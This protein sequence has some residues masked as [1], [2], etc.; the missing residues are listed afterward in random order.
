MA[1]AESPYAA[2]L[3]TQAKDLSLPPPGEDASA[4]AMRL[5]EGL[6]QR[7]VSEGGAI[8]FAEFME[9]AL[10]APGLGYYSAGSAKLGAAGDFVTAP[11][12]SPLFSRSL[13][14]QC[15]QM[16]GAVG[17]DVLEFGAGRGIM[18]ADLLLELEA[19]ECLPGAYLILEVSADLRE[20][21]RNTLMANAPHLLP[22]VRWIDGLPQGFRGVMLGNEVVDAMPV[23]L[24]KVQYGDAVPLGVRPEREG[25]AWC[26]LAGDEDL[27]R[28]Y[29][30]LCEELGGPLPEGYVS[31]AN[32]VQGPWLTSVLASLE[33]GLLLLID[34]GFPRREYYLP[35]R[36]AGTLMCHYRHHAH[37]DPLVLA[38]L[39]DITAHVD[40]TALAETA[41]AAGADV[42]GFTAQGQFLTA[43]GI[44]ELAQAAGEDVRT[45]LEVSAQL[46]RLLMP[47]EMGELFKLIAIGKGVEEPLLGFAGNDLR[48]RL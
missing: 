48:R 45:Q 32:L 17:G 18:A 39:Q 43:C 24:F 6:R 37:P 19:L 25:F 41:V 40:F 12:I 21:Q 28:W 44:L 35:E 46:K 47:H 11:E 33:A 14:R 9:Q 2:L 42:L 16:L 20:R 26:E 27:S 29:W 7:M 10:Y 31:E 30:A 8:R 22:R 4:V 34:Y 15:A 1:F 23:E 5:A 38:G 13:A 3:R 36:R